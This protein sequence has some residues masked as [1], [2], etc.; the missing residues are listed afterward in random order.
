M[1]L[2]QNSFKTVQKVLKL[3]RFSF[4]SLCGLFELQNIAR[5][6]RRLIC[7]QQKLSDFRWEFSKNEPFRTLRIVSAKSPL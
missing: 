2:K 5:N 7:A 1:K 4:I 6:G 3:F